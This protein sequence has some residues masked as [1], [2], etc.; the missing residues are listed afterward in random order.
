MRDVLVGV[1]LPQFTDDGDRFLDGARRAERLGLDSVWVFDHIWPLTGGR[2]RSALE[3][4]TS[5]AYVAACTDRV[6]IGTLVSR[7]SLRHPAVLA[8]MAAT[9]GEIAPGRL[10]VAIGSGDEASRA[11]NES[12][13]ITYFAGPDRIEQLEATVRVV[14]SYL[15]DDRVDLSSDYVEIAGLEPSPRPPTRPRV[16]VAGRADDA[17]DIAG[18]LADG[19]NGWGGSPDRFAQDAL[20]VAEFAGA[21]GRNVELTWAGLV[22]LALDDDRAHAELGS[23]SSED[24]IVG[25]P[26]TVARALSEFVDA[27]ARHLVC[28]FPKPATSDSYEL[29]A[30]KV[31]PLMGLR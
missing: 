13:G 8:K 3:C 16:W 26:E 19:W 30:E 31:L 18:R 23:R 6:G 20:R 5:L 1:T 9:V 28:T 15:S 7:S 24:R 29:L 11:E 21:G 25:G 14:T 12:Y 10:T 2:T 22:V 17:I 4:W 27:G